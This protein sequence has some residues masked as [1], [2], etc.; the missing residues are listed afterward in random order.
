MDSVVLCETVEEMEAATAAGAE[1]V[2]LDSKM[3]G[4]RCLALR[5]SGSGVG[6]SRLEDQ[7]GGLPS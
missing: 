2:A 1:I 7:C 3:I 5:G 4:V 6:H